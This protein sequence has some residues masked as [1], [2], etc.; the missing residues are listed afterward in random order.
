MMNCLNSGWNIMIVGLLM[1]CIMQGEVMGKITCSIF[2]IYL[3][4]L[5]PTRHVESSSNINQMINNH[6][7]SA[8]LKYSIILEDSQDMENRKRDLPDDELSKFG[9]EHH[10]CG[11]THVLH[12]A[13]EVHLRAREALENSPID[14]SF[15]RSLVVGDWDNIRI[16][17]DDTLVSNTD[18]HACYN[19][20]EEVDLYFQ[21]GYTCGTN[22]ILTSDIQT[23]F[24]E[25]VI[26]SM[27]S[28]LESM[29]NVQRVQGNLFF[30]SYYNG[31][32]GGECSLGVP[33]D[34]NLVEN[35]GGSGTPDS[36]FYAYF[37]AR[38]EHSSVI[39]T[40]RSCNHQTFGSYFGRPLAGHINFDPEYF[41][42]PISEFQFKANLRIGLHEITHAL[43]FSSHLF[44]DFVDSE[45]NLHQQPVIEV[46]NRGITTYLLTTPNV[47]E[48]T[49][50]HF[51]CN[52]LEGMEL[53]IKNGDPGSHWSKRNTYP[54]YMCPVVSKTMII[55]NLTLALFEDT[56]WYQVNW[57]TAENL[58]WGKNL[59]CD[60]VNEKCDASNTA[61]GNDGYY[62]SSS[63]T[64]GCTADRAAKGRCNVRDYGT[65][66]P[67]EYQYIDGSESLGGPSYVDYCPFIEGYSNTYCQNSEDSGYYSW[68]TFSD[69]SLCFEGTVS[70]SSRNLCIQTRCINGDLQVNI[71]GWEDCPEG[72]TV[73]LT[74]VNLDCPIGLCDNLDGECISADDCPSSKPV[75]DENTCKGCD[76]EILPCEN[77]LVCKSD[78]TCAQCDTSGDCSNPT[79]VCSS[80]ICVACTGGD[81]DVGYCADGSCFE[82]LQNSHCSSGLI[83][84]SDRTCKTCAVAVDGECDS[85]L[86]C[87][88][89]NDICVECVSN[90]HCDNP[91]PICGGSNSCVGCDDDCDYGLTCYVDGHCQECTVDD[92]CLNPEPICNVSGEVCRGCV[93]DTECDISL[94]C[95]S[96]ACY[97]CVN[98]SHC[99]G[100]TPV[101]DENACVSCDIATAGGCG[102]LFCDDSTG[103]CETCV[104]NDHCDINTPICSNFTCN[105]CSDELPCPGGGCSGGI[106]V[107]CTVNDHCLDFSLPVCDIDYTCK[108]CDESINECDDGSVCD[109]ATGI[110]VECIG[111]EDCDGGLI[112]DLSSGICRPCSEV[113]FGNC[114]NGGVCLSESDICVD[115]VFN[116]DCPNEQDYVCDVN[117]CV[118]CNVATEAECSFGLICNNN[119]GKCVQCISNSDCPEIQ[120]PICDSEKCRPCV[121]NTDCEDDPELGDVCI[122]SRGRC[123]DCPE[124]DLPSKFCS[125]DEP[126][127]SSL[128]HSCT[129]CTGDSQC[130]DDFFSNCVSGSCSECKT[131]GDCRDNLKCDSNGTGC[132]YCTSD[133]DC[134]GS[135]TCTSGFCEGCSSDDD[136]LLDSSPYCSSNTCVECL[137]SQHCGVDGLSC[138]D[139]KCVDCVSDSNCDGSDKCDTTINKCVSC[140]SNEDCSGDLGVCVF[141]LHEC[142][143]CGNDN[144]CNPLDNSGCGSICEYG[145]ERPTCFT[146]YNC[147]A[148]IG[149]TNQSC[150]STTCQSTGD[151]AFCQGQSCFPDTEYCEF[152]QCLEYFIP[153]TGE[154]D[155]EE[156]EG[157]ELEEGSSAALLCYYMSL[158]LA[159]MYI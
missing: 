86:F 4:V 138:S 59:G 70:S 11:S 41:L 3:F 76:S 39:A 64:E 92:H 83:C 5:F 89:S 95:F 147:D 71:N 104:I 79:P 47:L 48:K 12:N 28:I 17:V 127:C 123:G 61:W 84:D 119:S 142:E 30:D 37:T 93:N 42:P 97:E 45:G 18:N 112:C 62:C 20:G 130:I 81:C 67:I 100:S 63:S 31:L 109:E 155:T 72:T 111:N 134:D 23:M 141:H 145:D 129:T 118:A 82:C 128:T 46:E 33:I 133:S 7:D 101:C 144:D 88:I 14:T 77:N 13:A 74:E 105:P 148:V 66:L 49:R 6:L 153:P 159:V 54:E 9:L 132:V 91:L 65:S 40:A 87:D 73:S 51:D 150:G 106:C 43:G 126:I 10:D 154:E 22:D 113:V 108:R 103:L 85:G 56:G 69:S 136:C 98:N 78:G 124:Y 26:P 1:F 53:E 15:K 16:H 102:D 38:P 158:F 125:S 29:L 122:Q 32:V 34:D 146:G 8:W 57:E 107:D 99:S 60:F 143:E 80:D 55:S 68:E 2:L 152:G 149:N 116:E 151:Y 114:P 21:N 44:D 75:C 36:D 96:G 137:S 120:N 135:Q 19:V 157:R 110:C 115:C 25:S 131:D 140:A 27:V 156:E 24:K 58:L 52:T 94:T 139:G 50:E 35:G 121:S 90:T 117:E